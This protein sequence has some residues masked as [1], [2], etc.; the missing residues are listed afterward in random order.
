MVRLVVDQ[1]NFEPSTKIKFLDLPKRSLALFRM[2][3]SAALVI[4]FLSSSVLAQSCAP[5]QNVFLHA[6]SMKID[7][8]TEHILT[9][10]RNNPSH[11]S[12][13]RSTRLYGFILQ[14]EAEIRHLRDL[15]NIGDEYAVGDSDGRSSLR[16][17]LDLSVADLKLSLDLLRSKIGATLTTISDPILVGEGR[18]ALSL[19]TRVLDSLKTCTTLDRPR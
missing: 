1:P 6:A 7:S 4:L 10:Q 18:D 8:I 3:L 19:I 9:W 12:Y 11:P 5:N 14:F 13:E 17:F 16:T 15:L 2:I